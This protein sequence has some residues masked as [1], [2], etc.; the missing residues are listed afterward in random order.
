MFALAGAAFLVAETRARTPMLP[1]SMFGERTFCST[2]AVGLLVNVCFYGLI[3]VFSLLLQR[4]HGLSP[5]ST[6]LAFVPM[7]VAVGVA[8]V[9]SARLSGR[10][11]AR[12]VIALGLAAMAGGCVILALEVTVASAGEL[13]LMLVVFGAGAGLV[14]PPLTSAMLGSVPRERSGIASATLNSSR[15]TGSVIGVALFGSL[16]AGHRALPSG[17]RLAL[18]ISIGLLV[19]SCALCRRLGIEREAMAQRDRGH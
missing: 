10:L 3:F 5:L 18:V 11:G 14:V 8:N 9:G 4:V 12:G 1:L 17:T 2:T 13:A 19:A 16:I 15:Q 7:T 6:G